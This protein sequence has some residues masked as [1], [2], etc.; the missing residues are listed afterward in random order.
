MATTTLWK[1]VSF[2]C[3]SSPFGANYYFWTWFPKDLIGKWDCL[4]GS[5]QLT[6]SLTNFSQNE[7]TV[8]VSKTFCVTTDVEKLLAAWRKR[9]SHGEKAQLLQSPCGRSRQSGHESRLHQPQHTVPC[10]AKMPERWKEL[11]VLPWDRKRGYRARPLWKT[12]PCGL[13]CLQSN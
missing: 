12:Q 6:P 10:T 9:C 5:F 2:Q 4:P 13:A 1:Y 3:F 11:E 7:R 8:K